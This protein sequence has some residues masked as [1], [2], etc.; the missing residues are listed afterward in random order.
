MKIK[1]T[2]PDVKQGRPTKYKPEF[3]EQAYKLCLL[4]FIDKDLAAFFEVNED[5]INEWK[6]VY[7]EFSESLKNGKD[8]ADANVSESLYKR[9]CGYTH[10]AVKIFCNNGQITKE[11]YTEHY[12]PDTGAIALWLKNRQSKHW[13]DKQEIQHEGGLTIELVR[14]SD[15]DKP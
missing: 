6:K 12:P 9:A 7:P 3:A 1:T 8:L 5:S 14:F 10:D 13:R 2:K 11:K 15:I 4:G